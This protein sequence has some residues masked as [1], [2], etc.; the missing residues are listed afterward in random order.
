M[1]RYHLFRKNNPYELLDE[2]A[3]FQILSGVY[4]KLWL[5]FT[6]KR[7]LSMKFEFVKSSLSQIKSD[8]LAIGLFKDEQA[9]KVLS[10]LDRK[11]STKLADH[12][13]QHLANEGFKGNEKQVVS[14]P[15]FD[16]ISAERLYIVGLGASADYSPCSSRTA[17]ASVARRLKSNQINSSATFFIRSGSHISPRAK[18]GKRSKSTESVSQVPELN[19]EDSKE[20]LKAAVEGWV[21]G[22]FD[23]DKYKSRTDDNSKKKKRKPV[24]ERIGIAGVNLTQAEFSRS[25]KEAFT[26]ADSTNFARCLIAE[27]PAFMTPTRLSLEAKKIARDTGVSCKVLGIQQVEKLGMGSFLGVARGADEPPKFIV[28]KYTAPGAKK[29]IGLVGKGITF[30]SGGLS[31]K[32]SVG[33]E[34]M[35]YDMSGAAAVIAC[36]RVVGTLK[37]KVSVLAVVAATEN[38]PSGKALHPG[39]V[40]TAMNGKTIEVN[41]TDAEGRLVLADALTYALKENVDEVIDVA[42]LTGAVVQALGRVAAGIMGTDQPLIDKLIESGCSVGEKLW[43]LPLYNDYKSALKS[44]VADLKNA[45]SRG[46]AGSSCAGMFLKEFVD[47]KPWVHLDIAGV[48]WSDKEAGE[49][50]KGG[51]GFGV[52]TISNY[53][54]SK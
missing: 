52:R 40:L 6:K 29:T 14:I 2:I 27:P 39:D 36:M 41:N 38:M 32:T 22:I 12:V 16:M 21:L 48:A 26:V 42:T 1:I 20:H 46:Q 45:G 31:L 54:L 18:K 5:Q 34:R 37:P 53:I 50:N 13:K 44:D 25:A 17:A 51:T 43:Q 49:L 7:S 35:K 8:V 28:M 4:A 15:T 24:Q 23:F 33:M 9:A 47:G 10:Q 19:K 3:S 11:I 30:D